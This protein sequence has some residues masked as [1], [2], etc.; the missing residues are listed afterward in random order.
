MPRL[1]WFDYK[2]MKVTSKYLLGG[3][4]EY[5]Q[6]SGQTDGETESRLIGWLVGLEVVS[7]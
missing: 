2:W 1:L 7:F 3:N 6:T 4:E 5:K